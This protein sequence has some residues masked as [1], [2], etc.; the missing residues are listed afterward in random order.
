MNRNKLYWAGSLMVVAAIVLVV[1]LSAA[2]RGSFAKESRA[3]VA[4]VAAG[5]VVRLVEVAPGGGNRRIELT[6]ESRPFL[7]VTLYSQVSGYLKDVRV[8]KGDRVRRGDI[9]AVVESPEA[10][11][12]Y[13]S[14]IADAKNKRVIAQR[15]SQLII[16]KLIAPEE[17]ETAETEA[18]QA[19]AHASALESM[20]G[21][22]I[23]RAPFNGVI[24]A[25]YADP[26]ALVQNAQN[27][28][29]SSLPVVAVGTID[30]LRIFVYVDQRDAGD[31][32]RGTPVTIADPSRP[33]A[34]LSGSVTRFTGELDPDTRTLLAEIDVPNHHGLLVP[35]S[36]VQV[37]LDVHAAPYLHVPS[38]AV[39][40]NGQKNY[41][42]VVTRENRIAVREVHV[43]E[44]DG[45]IVR[46]TSDS[47]RAGEH[48]ALDVG[49]SIPNGGQVQPAN[50]AP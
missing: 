14:A 47:V 25:R 41:I 26:G 38:A 1:V 30:S 35:G 28:Q 11:E 2:R 46:F 13:A 23:L 8:D 37:S 36:I 4:A 29:T 9:L 43:V 50:E 3:R 45:E 39:F 33:G 20:K 5:P 44:N 6:G 10:D 32:Q 7:S 16:Q 34:E 12:A 31:V 19:E 49:N 22:E 48:V 40:A 27:A 42:A 15:D 21:Y 18:V 24:T 17:A